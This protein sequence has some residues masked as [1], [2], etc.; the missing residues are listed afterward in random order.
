MLGCFYFVSCTIDVWHFWNWSLLCMCCDI[1]VVVFWGERQFIKMASVFK[2]P[3]VNV[4]VYVCVSGVGGGG[5]VEMK[6]LILF[7]WL[8]MGLSYFY[9]LFYLLFCFCFCIIPV[10]LF[11]YLLVLLWVWVYMSSHV[12]AINIDVYSAFAV[13]LNILCLEVAY[14]SIR[15]FCWHLLYIYDL[16]LYFRLC[17]TLCVI[18]LVSFMQS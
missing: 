13:I 6:E 4:C 17:I 12:I 15:L 8:S 11:Y 2:L 10:I 3:D 16:I 9:L 18:L 7:K 14:N 5:G 1:Y